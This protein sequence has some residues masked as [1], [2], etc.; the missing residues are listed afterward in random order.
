VRLPLDFAK[1]LYTVTKDG[2]T[3]IVT[4]QKSASGSTT[5]PGLLFAA[6][7]SAAAPKGGVVWKPAK[8]PTGPVSVVVSSADGAAY[9]FRNGVE[10]G[11]APV[12]GLRRF[13]G[14]YVYSAL[15][16][17]DADGSRDWLTLASVGGRPPE[18]RDLVKKVG[19]DPQFLANARALITPGTTLILTD[20]PV[21]VSTRSGKGFN[22]LTTA[23]TP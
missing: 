13:T 21:S 19:V 11:R 14:S 23:E 17:V 22:I 12:A 3:V 1:Q 7:P 16:K 10:I 5:A 15:T 18:L 9:V 2:T 8:A 4:N 20:T 6:T